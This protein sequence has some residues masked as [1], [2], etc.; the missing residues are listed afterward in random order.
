M[1]QEGFSLLPPPGLEAQ[2]TQDEVGLQRLGRA[3]QHGLGDAG[4]L[5]HLPALPKRLQQGHLDIQAGGVG[6]QD[7][8]KLLDGPVQHLPLDVKAAQTGPAEAQLGAGGT[9]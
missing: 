6:L 9:V 3:F 8:A 5:L 1:A 7:F 4:R 2:V